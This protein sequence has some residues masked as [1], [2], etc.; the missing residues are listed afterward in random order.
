MEAL[1]CRLLSSL[2]V[3]WLGRKDHLAGSQKSWGFAPALRTSCT[4]WA[5]LQLLPT[6][7]KRRLELH[8][9]GAPRLGLRNNSRAIRYELGKIHALCI[10]AH[11]GPMRGTSKNCTPALLGPL[12]M[13]SVSCQIEPVV[14]ERIV[15]ESGRP[16][17]S[18]VVSLR[19][20]HL[21]QHLPQCL[22]HNDL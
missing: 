14:G 19:A 4:P 18:I 13:T 7:E 2:C 17:Y 20:N 6:P 11:N 5:G 10:T 22:I 8:D 16:V 15:V 21:A 9:H 12:E 1:R 3:E